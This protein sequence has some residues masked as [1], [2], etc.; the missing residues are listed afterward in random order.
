[1]LSKHELDIKHFNH[2]SSF[3]KDKYPFFDT[4]SSWIIFIS[5]EQ[6][7]DFLDD[8]LD[9]YVD[10]PTLFLYSKVNKGACMS[11]IEQFRKQNNLE[12]LESDQ[13]LSVLATPTCDKG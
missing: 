9:R 13:E 6:D 11:S 7:S 10:K 5:D 2:P 8:F 1:M 12:A 3:K 4:I